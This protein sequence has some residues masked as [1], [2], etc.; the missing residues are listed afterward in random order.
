MDIQSTLPW[1]MAAGAY[2]LLLALGPH[3]LSDPDISPTSRLV[4]GFSITT[5]FPSPTR[6]RQTFAEH[7]GLRSSDSR[8]PRLREHTQLE[9][10]LASSR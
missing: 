4:A 6:S 3:L 1:L 5:L 2:L 9:V 7:T 8:R 10:G